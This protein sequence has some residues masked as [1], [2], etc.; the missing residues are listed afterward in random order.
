MVSKNKS[1]K[2][3]DEMPQILT[4]KIFLFFFAG[5]AFLALSI[6]LAIALHDKVHLTIA[7]FG[8]AGLGKAAFMKYQWDYGRIVAGIY[9]CVGITPKKNGVKALCTAV[10]RDSDIL[11]ESQ[12]FFLGGERSIIYQGATI[13]VYADRTSPNDIIAW[14]FC[15][16]SAE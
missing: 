7:L 2:N 12:E 13:R 5:L 4:K 15:N 10:Q 16:S 11:A 3:T 1:E 6:G 14:E 9:T 8:I